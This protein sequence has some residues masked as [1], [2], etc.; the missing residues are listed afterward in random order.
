MKPDWLGVVIA[1][2][3][4]YFSY[5]SQIVKEAGIHL[6]YCTIAIF[7]DSMGKYTYLGGIRIARGEI[8]KRDLALQP[9]SMGRSDLSG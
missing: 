5:T 1:L 6:S 4:L 7:S 9:H 3:V 8:L 2:I